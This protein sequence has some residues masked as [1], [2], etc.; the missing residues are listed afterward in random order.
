MKIE[1]H[2]ISN[3][4]IRKHFENGLR[5][6]VDRQRLLTSSGLSEELIYQPLARATPQVMANLIN[7]VARERDD[8]F[9][10]MTD[11]TVRCGSFAYLAE[12][13]VAHKTLLDVY[14]EMSRFYNLVAGGVRF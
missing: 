11:R 10:G 8:E 5:I 6:G 1:N 7:C 3:F 4:Y 9:L 13:L 14:Q 2:T 12:H